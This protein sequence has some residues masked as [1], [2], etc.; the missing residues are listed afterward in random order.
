MN[1]SPATWNAK[2]ERLAVLIAAGKSIKSAAADTEIGERTAH[3]WL[4]DPRYR[5]FVAE[6]RGRMFDEAVGSLADATNE[7]VGALRS[8]LN[9]GN[10]NIRL[11][12]ATAIID[13]ALKLRAHVELDR[14]VLALEQDTAQ[15]GSDAR[16]RIMIPDADPRFR[17]TDPNG[18]EEESQP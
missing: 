5:T 8:L 12:A 15:E 13:N 4:A 14:R 2:Q 3:D 17:R 10:S 9:D 18:W 7:A 16:P 11:K 1:E 6:I